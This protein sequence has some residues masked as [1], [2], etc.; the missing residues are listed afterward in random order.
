MTPQEIQ[1]YI[2]CAK[3]PIYFLNNYGYVYDIRKS[4]V[5][6]LSCFE[7]QE[8]AIRNFVKYQNNIVLKS[9]QC[10]PEDT[11][12]S[13]PDGPK[14]IKEINKGDIIY[15]YN[16]QKNKHELDT[17]YDHWECGEIEC[18]KIKLKDSR[19]IT[20]GENHPFYIKNKNKWV[21]A[22]DLEIDDE[23]LDQKFQF[24]EIE[25]DINEIKLLAYLITDGS[26]I[27]QVKFTNN[28]LYYLNEFEESV[29]YIFPELSL[30]KIPKLKSGGSNWDWHSSFLTSFS[31]LFFRE[32]KNRN[33]FLPLS[34]LGGLK[35]NLKPI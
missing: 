25:A 5:D 12:V 18:V 31:S 2:K 9:R 3:D 24:G 7:Y 22:K 30:R 16:L 20:V 4:K 8:N 14:L 13:T 26:T 19:N 34:H 28:N 21:S 32:M 11:F 33:T 6:K 1:E 27:K 23:I 10:L 29:N 17:V 15:S 35:F